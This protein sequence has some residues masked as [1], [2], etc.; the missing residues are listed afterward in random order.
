MDKQYEPLIQALL[1][2]KNSVDVD[3]ICESLYVIDFNI[4]KI[5]LKCQQKS[6]LYEILRTLTTLQL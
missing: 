5:K 6:F 3:R 1:T 2:D 4:L